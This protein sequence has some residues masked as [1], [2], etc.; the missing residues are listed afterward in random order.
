MDGDAA[1]G[2]ANNAA[3][4]AAPNN[5]RCAIMP[6][7]QTYPA[8][9]LALRSLMIKCSVVLALHLAEQIDQLV[10]FLA[11]LGGI[12]GADCIGD[13]AGRVIF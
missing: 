8:R 6:L 4:N 1:T 10:E 3:I 2:D 5:I 11:L 13:T 12:A 9:T 7:P